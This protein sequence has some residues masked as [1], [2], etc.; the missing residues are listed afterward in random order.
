MDCPVAIENKTMS[1][2]I[3]I[4]NTDNVEATIKLHDKSFDILT[5][6]YRLFCRLRILC[7]AWYKQ[8]IVTLEST[9]GKKEGIITFSQTRIFCHQQG[10]T[11]A[12]IRQ[13]RLQTWIKNIKTEKFFNRTELMHKIRA[14][15][16]RYLDI[17]SFTSN[18]ALIINNLDQ[19]TNVQLDEVVRE[20]KSNKK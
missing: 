10:F 20:L 8:G 17:S 2:I 3:T 12:V 13:L 19:L 6:D 4:E 18:S 7:N 15:L 5:R 14:T 16:T 1:V 11:V 9:H